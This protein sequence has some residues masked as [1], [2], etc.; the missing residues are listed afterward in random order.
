MESSENPK[1]TVSTY[2]ENTD[3]IVLIED[4]GPGM[5]ANQVRRIFE[6]FHTTKA[7]GTGLGLAVTHKIFESHKA[8]VI[9]ESEVG[10]GT[11]FK[12]IFHEGRGRPQASQL[13]V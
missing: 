8:D 4:K 13:A 1:L 12:I 10:M 9:V 11:T 6:P 7:K 2:D 5:D 3:V